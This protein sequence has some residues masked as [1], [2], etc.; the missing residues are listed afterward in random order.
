[1]SLT[2]K[3]L[4]VC[5]ETEVSF[6]SACCTIAQVIRYLD[7]LSVHVSLF[8]STC[9]R[10]LILL[11]SSPFCTSVQLPLAWFVLLLPTYLIGV[12]LQYSCSEAH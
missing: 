4:I 11:M 9:Y 2:P 7:A 1:M 6:L 5:Y 8:F 12:A 3:N 10:R